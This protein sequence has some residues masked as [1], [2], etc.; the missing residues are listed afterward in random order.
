MLSTPW[1]G[2]SDASR[3]WSISAGVAVICTSSSAVW[4]APTVRLEPP[5][6]EN[7]TP[8]EST[9]VSMPRSKVS[10]VVPW[11]TTRTRLLCVSGPGAVASGSKVTETRPVPSAFIATTCPW[12]A[13][14]GSTRP[15]PMR[16]RPN[17]GG[18]P[19]GNSVGLCSACPIASALSSSTDQLGWS[20][21]SSAIVPAMCGLAIEVPEMVSA[22]VPTWMPDAS[23][24]PVQPPVEVVQVIPVWTEVMLVPG[25]AMSGLRR[26]GDP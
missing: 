1:V 19:A 10:A 24:R 16:A 25:A 11:L 8:G 4:P 22:R 5:G 20:W 21:R 6:S 18:V 26:S 9:T 2:N 14:A 15:A 12:A 13:S 17:S 23:N 3:V 7:A